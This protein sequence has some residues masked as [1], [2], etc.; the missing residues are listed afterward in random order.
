MPAWL[1]RHCIEAAGFSVSLG[2]FPALIFASTFQLILKTGVL[3]GVV[4][5]LGDHLDQDARN[6][7]SSFL[8]CDPAVQFLDHDKLLSN[9]QTDRYHHP[10]TSLELVDQG[11]EESGPAR[12]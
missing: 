2:P 6:A 5:P 3:P 12:P 9:G 4:P 7:D 10:S 8:R 11:E 1:R